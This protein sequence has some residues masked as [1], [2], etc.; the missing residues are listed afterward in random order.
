[1]KCQI[2]YARK[3]FICKMISAL[4]TVLLYSLNSDNI[5]V[6]KFN[7]GLSLNFVMPLLLLTAVWLSHADM[8]YTMLL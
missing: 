2:L 4:A 5:S 1:V 8:R 7:A 3:S 6:I